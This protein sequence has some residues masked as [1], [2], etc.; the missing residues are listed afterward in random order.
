MNSDLTNLLP[1]ERQSA[2]AREYVLRVGV[3]AM[4]LLTILVFMA[5]ALLVPA[6]VYLTKAANLKQVRLTAISA[7][8]SSSDGAALSARLATLTSNATT[9]STLVKSTTASSVIRQILTVPHTGVLLSGLSYSASTKT[10]LTIT[11][12]GV[13]TTRDTLRSYQLAL[14]SAPFIRSAIVPV[15]VFAQD[16][17]IGF[18]MS[19]TLSP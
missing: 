15:S 7:S 17:N 3:V 10:P 19:V 9:L 8:L 5:A 12:T 4:V 13:A 1:I 6:Y 2:L 11:L 18:T 14:Q 16:I